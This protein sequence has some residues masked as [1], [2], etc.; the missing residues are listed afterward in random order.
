MHMKAGFACFLRFAATASFT[1]IGL[2]RAPQLTVALSRE[3]A[4]TV[5][6]AESNVAASVEMALKD[7]LGPVGLHA[8]PQKVPELKAWCVTERIRPLALLQLFPEAFVVEPT[9]SDVSLLCVRLAH[10][11]SPAVDTAALV[12]DG[13]P[14]MD[15]S[16]VADMLG[17]RLGTTLSK[18]HAH[19]PSLPTDPVPLSWLVRSMPS[20]IEALVIA[21]PEREWFFH[22]DPARFGYKDRA[23][24]WSACRD[25][26]LRRFVDSRQEQFTWHERDDGTPA[27][28]MTLAEVSRRRGCSAAESAISMAEIARARHGVLTGL[29][30]AQRKAATATAAMASPDP[31]P[32]PAVG[33]RLYLVR[34]SARTVSLLDEEM[35][36]AAEY[37]GLAPELLRPLTP[38]LWL[39]VRGTDGG[40][41]AAMRMATLLPHLAAVRGGGT[42]LLG[43]STAAAMVQ[44]LRGAHDCDSLCRRVFRQGPW[45]CPPENDK[46]EQDGRTGGAQDGAF[47]A[48]GAHGWT[49]HVEQHYPPADQRVLPFHCLDDVGELC[50]ALSRALDRGA[51]GVDE[52]TESPS[53][54]PDGVA[55]LTLLVTKGTVLLLREDDPAP[56]KVRVDE[57]VAEGELPSSRDQL[58]LPRWISAWDR[59]AF[60]FSAALDPIVAQAS[61]NIALHTHLKLH[62]DQTLPSDVHSAR[63]SAD[64]SHAQDDTLR[65]FDPCLGSGTILA[66]AAARGIRRIVGADINAEFVARARSNLLDARLLGSGVRLF[67]HDAA[68]PYLAED[69]DPLS[70]S[71]LDPGSLSSHSQLDPGSLSRTLVVSNPPWGNNI[72]EGLDG[73]AIVTSVTSQFAGAT[74]CWIAN[75][76]AVEALRCLPGVTVLRH[77]PFGSVELVVC[78]ASRF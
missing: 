29:S 34:G 30:R 61:L 52:E 31:L 33:S 64:P 62:P 9:T 57:G 21:A 10:G 5:T 50:V 58:R 19:R 25:A 76:L 14:S 71:Q 35:R 38:G 65:V 49:L 74:M 69:L 7:A 44:L 54:V 24:A 22:L 60:F 51:L 46:D 70:H 56:P 36:S 66:A 2:Q 27:I 17:E 13:T 53:L 37:A 41:P 20:P 68:T 40:G 55:H 67:V 39:Q 11:G 63:H 16:G 75:P 1:R 47:R 28:S 23:C 72:G 59:R 8:L 3:L 32:S 78:T 48:G 15:A 77:V 18:Y 26:H 6:V 42:L 45:F 4:M 73:K 12:D 43:A